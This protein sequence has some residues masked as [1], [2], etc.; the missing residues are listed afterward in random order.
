MAVSFDDGLFRYFQTQYIPEDVAA[1]AAAAAAPAAAAAGAAGVVV[2][3]LFGDKHLGNAYL[4]SVFLVPYT[5]T[6]YV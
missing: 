2:S 1:A 3:V 5:R 4:V 6:Y